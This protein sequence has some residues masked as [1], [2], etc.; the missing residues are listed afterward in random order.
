MQQHGNCQTYVIGVDPG[1]NGAIAHV[2]LGRKEIWIKTTRVPIFRCFNRRYLQTGQLISL[3]EFEWKGVK[4]VMVCC[5]ALQ[6]RP[7]PTGRSAN[8]NAG[9]W[10]GIM[11]TFGAMT[12]QNPQVK[13]VRPQL[14]KK[15][16]GL[17]KMPKTESV[18]KVKDLLCVTDRLRHDD[19][20]AILIAFQA[21][22]DLKDIS[23]EEF[24]REYLDK[25]KCRLVVGGT[26]E[27]FEEG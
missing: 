24:K 19:A 17:L 12:G 26:F 1:L 3:L 5:E 13:F 14:W 23:F 8:F 10:R 4:P 21:L 11:E 20:D 25:K 27:M 6:A 15:T 9:I 16:F 22:L 7:A 2:L 18:V